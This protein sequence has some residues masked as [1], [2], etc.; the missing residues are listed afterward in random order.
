MP[1][2]VK[3]PAV[4]AVVCPPPAVPGGWRVMEDAAGVEARF[5]DEAGSL[6]G[7]ALVGGACARKNALAKLVPPVLG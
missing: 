3:T 2:V 7:F 4:P 6:L 1:V 5:E